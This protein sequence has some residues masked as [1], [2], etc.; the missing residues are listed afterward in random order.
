M[1]TLFTTLVHYREISELQ[2]HA[3]LLIVCN[4]ILTEVLGALVSI[5]IIYITTGILLYLAVHRVI[6][7]EYEINAD[8]MLITAGL[9]VAFNIM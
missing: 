2:I 8:E 4:F 7:S 1:T 6:N 9:G 3:I 5:I